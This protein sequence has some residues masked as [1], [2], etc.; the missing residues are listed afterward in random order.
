MATVVSAADRYVSD[1]GTFTAVP[2]RYVRNGSVLVVD[3]DLWRVLY[4]RRIKKE[5]L[6]KVGDARAFH[7]V[8]EATLESK[9]QAG[10]GVVADLS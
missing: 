4:L 6:A 10:S 3:P 7:L 5:E 8:T 9:N 1:F 2:S